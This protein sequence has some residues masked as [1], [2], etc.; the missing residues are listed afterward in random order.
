[1]V[2]RCDHA[3]HIGS[4][5]SY[6]FDKSRQIKRVITRIIIIIYYYY[7][8]SLINYEN[9]SCARKRCI[10]YSCTTRPMTDFH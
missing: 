1:M 2:F 9:G 3:L 5:V 6:L 4:L 8:Y 7:Y 10:F